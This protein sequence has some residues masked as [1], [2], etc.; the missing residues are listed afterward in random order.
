[1]LIVSLFFLFLFS[2][3]EAVR[4]C[5]V[6]CCSA[7]LYIIDEFSIDSTFI[8][9]VFFL[10]SCWHPLQSICFHQVSVSCLS[11]FC[12]TDVGTFWSL[13]HF[14]VIPLFLLLAICHWECVMTRAHFIPPPRPSLSF[15]L[16]LS[17]DVCL[18]SRD[19][20]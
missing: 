3:R 18:S 19:S 11:L 1:M 5:P 14:E 4:A 2:S 13:I 17:N 15:V 7:C 16:C 12:Q 9:S 6:L 10:F 20:R 8:S